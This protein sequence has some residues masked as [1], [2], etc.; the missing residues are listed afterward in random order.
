MRSEE[1][2]ILEFNQY[3]NLTRHHLLFMLLSS[4]FNLQL[5]KMDK[6]VNNPENVSTTKVSAY[7]DKD[8]VKKLC[9]CLKIT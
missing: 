4:I 3:Q 7:R 8:Y 6:C 9:E 5:K 2:K 1:T